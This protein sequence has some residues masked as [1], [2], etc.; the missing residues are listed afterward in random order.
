MGGFL[1]G[2]A[3][4]SNSIHENK[5]LSFFGGWSDTFF[6]GDIVCIMFNNRAYTAEQKRFKKHAD[7]LKKEFKARYQSGTQAVID[8]GYTEFIKEAATST[9]GRRTKAQKLNDIMPLTRSLVS[10]HVA[11]KLMATLHTLPYKKEDYN[12]L[13]DYIDMYHMGATSLHMEAEA[14]GKPLTALVSTALDRGFQLQMSEAMDTWN[15]ALRDYPNAQKKNMY[16][17]HPA[18][19]QMEEKRYIER[20]PED[21]EYL[22][23]RVKR[24]DMIHND[25]EAHAAWMKGNKEAVNQRVLALHMKE[26]SMKRARTEYEDDNEEQE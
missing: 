5:L 26:N 21:E 9:G 23:G 10:S 14:A 8:R 20:T 25:P 17:R 3:S 18:Y 15:Q 11:E 6:S 22:E 13:V 2:R 12:D 7:K 24:G 1:G 4:V 16:F 19:E